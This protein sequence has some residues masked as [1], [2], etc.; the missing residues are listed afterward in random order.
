MGA[1]IL[2]TPE[3][4]REVLRYDPDTG[5]LF[6]L[7]RPLE[8]FSAEMYWKT[9]HSRFAGKEAFT[10]YRPD[11]YKVGRF[12]GMTLRAHR[13]A[14][15]IHHGAWPEEE[16]DHQNLLV[17]DNRMENLRLASSAQNKWN[18]GMKST[19]TSGLKGA[20][21]SKKESCWIAQIGAAGR[22]RRIGKFATAEAAHEAYKKEALKLRGGY[23]RFE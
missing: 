13:V 9:W 20:S 3:Q 2:P 16:I 10:A 22:P 7:N 4:L 14:W 19:N 8:M 15:T 11:G 18:Q 21:W 5:K 1:H 12:M 23:A 6:W 17:D